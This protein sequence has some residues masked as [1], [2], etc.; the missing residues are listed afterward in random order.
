[1]TKNIYTE[2]YKASSITMKEITE[3]MRVIAKAVSGLSTTIGEP[4][5]CHN[6]WHQLDETLWECVECGKIRYE[7]HN[8]TVGNYILGID[9]SYEYYDSYK[10]YLAAIL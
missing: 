9:I 2:L 7:N 5:D 3:T 1:M 10:H 8:P 6:N 4:C